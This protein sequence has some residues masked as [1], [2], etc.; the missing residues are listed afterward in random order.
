MSGLSERQ[1][2]QRT[3]GFTL[4]TDVSEQLATYLSDHP[5]PMLPSRVPEKFDPLGMTGRADVRIDDDPAA[6]R[7]YCTARHIEDL[8]PRGRELIQF[9]A[10]DIDLDGRI[11]QYA[12]AAGFGDTN[13]P[14]YFSAG[15]ANACVDEFVNTGA[16]TKEQKDKLT[17]HDWANVIG[18]GWFSGLVHD[19]AL[20]KNLVYRSFGDKPHDYDRGSLQRMLCIDEPPLICGE[21]YEPEEDRTYHVAKLGKEATQYLRS[22]M[23]SG[24]SLGCPVARRSVLLPRKL[25]D[26]D[27]HTQHLLDR[28]SMNIV[29]KRSTETHVRATVEWTAIDTTLAVFANQLDQYQAVYGEPYLKGRSGSRI[30]IEHREA[31]PIDALS[32]PGF[33]PATT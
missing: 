5:V 26:T 16:I 2:F 31:E 19:M 24:D 23:Q 4:Y 27:I 28:G 25:V 12:F 1:I 29:P 18:T 11:D 32:W 30:H 3:D 15:L 17:L 20:T 7:L 9:G 8:V 6:M 21:K 10:T 22:A 33:G 14:W 13:F